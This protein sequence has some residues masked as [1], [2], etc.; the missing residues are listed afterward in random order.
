MNTTINASTENTIETG[1]IQSV[2]E[3]TNLNWSVSKQ[4]I[5]TV[6]GILIPEKIA[7]VRSDNNAILGIHTNNYEPFQNDKML[8]L[9]Y[10]ISQ[11]SGL[12]IH[13]TG[14]FGGG[15]KIY[16]QLENENFRLSDGDQ[17]KSYFTSVNSHDGSTQ[18][19]FGTTSIT[20]SCMNSFMG[21]YKSLETKMKHTKSMVVKLDNIL[22]Q[23]D[24]MKR[25]EIANIQTIEK[26]A[27]VNIDSNSKMLVTRLLF[28]LQKQDGYSIN[29]L[30]SNETLSTRKKNQIASFTDSLAL[31]TAQK[32]ENLW[33]LFSGMTR[34]TTHNMLNKDTTEHKMF[35]SLG[36]KE[37]K[38]FAELAEL[39]N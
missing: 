1:L 22:R 33:G 12:K 29:E 8:E 27:N 17:I 39:V 34:F 31:E 20:I 14:T 24:I 7:I 5:Q 26:M 9:L 23:L 6:S 30:V 15:E 36:V 13:K 3:S 16:I 19:G 10:K 2:L 4:P 35:G 38:V 32:G 18:F 11:S 37:R 25:E 21:A 28:D